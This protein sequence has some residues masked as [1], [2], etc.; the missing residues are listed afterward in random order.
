M[1]TP[2][3]IDLETISQTDGV[4]S[5]RVPIPLYDDPYMEIRQAYLATITDSKF[6]PFEDFRETE[7]PQPL[8]IASSPV[9]SS[10]DPYLIEFEASE[11]SD[12]RITSSHSTAPSDATTPLSPNHPV[13][14]TA[15]T[16]TLSRPLYY[17]KTARMAVH[18]QPTMSPG[19]PIRVTEAMTLSPS[20]FCKR[21]VPDQQVVDETPTHRIHVRT[22]WIDPEDDTVYLDIEIDPLSRAPVQTSASPEWS[23][24]SLPVSPASMTVPS[25]IALLVTTPTSTIAVDEDEFLEVE[26]QLELHGSILHDHTQRLDALPPTLLE[27]HDQDITELLDKSRAVREEIHS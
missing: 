22:I 11:L 1:S 26:V 18:T 10:D 6:G 21:S 13:T 2:A 14:Q 7:I 5:S 17:R 4:R 25:P 27:G 16:L 8:P 3:H 20:S 24:G 12:T 23:S 19:L 15:P 9:P